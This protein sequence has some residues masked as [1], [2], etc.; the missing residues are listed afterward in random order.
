LATYSRRKQMGHFFAS[1]STVVIE[2]LLR[3]EMNVKNLDKGVWY[4][5]KASSMVNARFLLTRSPFG[6]MSRR[7]KSIE[8]RNDGI[9]DRLNPVSTC[10]Q[11]HRVS[12]QSTFTK[13]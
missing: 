2:S 5:S 3:W 13:N 12:H 4:V 10:S 7:G 6:A 9:A 1:I 8:S 11:P